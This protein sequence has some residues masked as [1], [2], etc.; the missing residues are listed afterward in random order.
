MLALAVFALAA[1]A[2]DYG[3]V[4]QPM[5]GNGRTGA[6]ADGPAAPRGGVGT[7]TLVG[8]TMWRKHAVI[9]RR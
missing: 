4:A 3:V 2:Q 7:L 8:V 5:P 6:A 9:S 1:L